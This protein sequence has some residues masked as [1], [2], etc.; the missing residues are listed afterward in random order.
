MSKHAESCVRR[1]IVGVMAMEG[2]VLATFLTQPIN[3]TAYVV[4]TAVGVIGAYT[5]YKLHEAI[6]P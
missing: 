3:P 4:C 5:A 1:A 2:I 6:Y